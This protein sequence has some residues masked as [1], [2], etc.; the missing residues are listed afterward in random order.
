L[1][2]TTDEPCP[3]SIEIISSDL[4]QL[5]LRVECP[6]FVSE[7]VTHEESEYSRLTFP[8]LYRTS[9]EGSPWLP[10]VRQLIAVPADCAMNVSVTL[11][12][13][14][15]FSGSVLYPVPAT[16]VC[17]TEEGWEYYDHEFA[18]DEEAYARGGYYPTDVATVS[19]SGSFRGQGVALL[20]V[21]P[22]QFDA[23]GLR[24]RALHSL[25]VT[26]TFEG[27]TGG[28]GEDVGPF[29][30]IA[31]DVLVNYQGLSA[32]ERGAAGAGEYAHC[33]SVADCDS[34]RADYLMIVEHTL[35][36]SG[37]AHVAALA[38]H[39]AEFDGWNVAI[40]SDT[41]ITGGG[42]IS[43]E[44]IKNFIQAVYETRSAE[45]MSDGRLGYVLLV[46]DA[47]PDGDEMIPAHEASDPDD[48]EDSITTDTWYAC[49]KDDD[50][51][52]DLAIGRL[53]ADE[54]AELETEVTKFVD[55]ETDA[56]SADAW[57]DTVFLSCGFAWKNCSNDDSTHFANHVDSAFVWIRQLMVPLDYGVREL[58][59]HELDGENCGEQR[60]AARTLNLREVNAG[61][62]I[63]ELC[64][65]GG[66]GGTQ[67]FKKAQADALANSDAL[68]FWMSYS[69][70]TGQY[71]VYVAELGGWD[72]F[73][74]YLMHGVGPNGVVGYFGDSEGSEIAATTYLGTYVWEALFRNRERRLGEA[75][76]YA[77]MKHFSVTGKAREVLSYT[78][79]G[80][81]A[82]DVLIEDVGTAGYGAAPD[83]LVSEADLAT[84]PQFPSVGGTVSLRAL[85]HNESNYN[86]DSAIDIL[87][88]VWERDASVRLF[89]GTTTASPM[90]WGSDVAEVPWA[91]GDPDIGHL[92]LRV[93]VD[94]EDSQSELSE[95]NNM[96]EAPFGVYFEREGFPIDTQGGA[97]LAVTLADIHEAPGLEV[98]APA[99]SPGRLW[100]RT[101]TGEE[102]WTFTAPSDATL[103]GAPAVGDLTM[104]GER[105]VALS[106]GDYV[107]VRSGATGDEKAGFPYAVSGAG[108]ACA[109]GDFV[110]GDGA[111]EILVE[112]EEVETGHGGDLEVFALVFVTDDGSDSWAWE[113][114]ISAVV[115]NPRE[116]SPAVADLNGDGHPDVVSSTHGGPG[117][118][119]QVVVLDG[120]TSDPLWSPA[121]RSLGIWEPDTGG[122]AVHPCN[123][124]VADAHPGSA[125]LEVLCG[126]HE[127]HCFTVTGDVAVPS[128]TVQGFMSGLAATDLDGDG[129]VEIVAGTYGSP[130]HPGECGGYLYVF[131]NEGG[132]W[133]AADS[134]SL[135]YSCT[136]QPVIA[137][138][139][140]DSQPE[141]IIGSSCRHFVGPE[142]RDLSHI[143]ILTFDP[144]TGSLDQF[145]EID[146][147]L[148]FWG[149]LVSTP[150]VAD[151]D[152]NEAVELWLV[153]GEGHLH[154]LEH[155]S[156]GQPSRWASYQHDARHTGTYET[157]VSGAYPD[158]AQIS[159]WGDYLMTGDVEIDGTS[160]ML[161]QPGTTVRVAADQD[162]Q[163]AGADT[164]LT[165]LVID[166]GE[167]AVAGLAADPVC[168]FSA[169]DDPEPGDWQGIRLLDDS[170]GSLSNCSVRHAFIGVDAE[171]LDTVV[172]EHCKLED[173]DVK[174]VRCDGDAGGSG[175]SL[176]GNVVKE[177]QV[178]IELHR[179]S[180]VVVGDSIVNCQSHGM[181]IY[182]DYGSKIVSNTL[183]APPWAQT[184]FSGIYVQASRESLRIANNLITVPSTAIQYEL[185]WYTDEGRIEDNTIAGLESGPCPKGMS[186][187]DG[188]P[189]VRGNVVGGNLHAAYWIDGW[190]GA[191]PELGEAL[192][193]TSC[194]SC[195]DTTRPGCNSVPTGTDPRYYVRVT[196]GFPN[197]VKAE[198][199]WWEYQYEKI[200]RGKFVGPVDWEPP[201]ASD[202]A[203]RGESPEGP[204]SNV[205]FA[206]FQNRPNPFNPVTTI[207]FGIP[208]EVSVR[209]G[210][211]DLAGRRVRTLVDV[212]KEPGWYE[213]T[214]DGRN[215][216]GLLVASGV[217]FCRLEAG[218]SRALRK[219]VVL[220]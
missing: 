145:A 79:L 92:I 103:H 63:V 45:H 144:T 97:G 5:V 98:L 46:G 189:M 202:P 54:V 152:E 55:Y 102:L 44:F 12:D 194:P 193:D 161:I 27:G 62:H 207:R 28:L 175:I 66:P 78:L 113:S 174:G 68:P 87:F 31:E 126:G 52:P 133:S 127:L 59:A 95:D 201:L 143:D 80:D 197:T 38:Q 142:R 99:R 132:A 138:L 84:S 136:G 181:K 165:E 155:W 6:G 204:A 72:C 167:L 18:K 90:A 21:Y 164:T 217:Y 69:C 37:Y 195:T 177:T 139:N 74:E 20:T 182:Q 30:R 75:I 86:P 91:P 178:G 112:R 111:L 34:I 89:A 147:P 151:A 81:P 162:D 208:Q 130:G 47:R 158:G 100:V 212:T 107:T 93:T 70:Y 4:E 149:S 23:A 171:S 101:S 118:S 64:V 137:D 16:V 58:H 14:V 219:L 17:Y 148:F 196:P 216:A 42:T 15:V 198:C 157:P 33:T 106:Y 220:K 115:P 141:I 190:A 140:G 60:T 159:W 22:L 3:P 19:E 170:I 49:V 134:V 26:L 61:R 57:R 129:E 13:S 210:I 123:P 109:L 51:Y 125:G 9:E 218:R 176:L 163:H 105:E 11:G 35:M 169:A 211:Y 187:Y 41:T 199:N 172:I 200:D 184:A 7:T 39:R 180:A 154:S 213:V 10:A 117:S 53:C 166:G 56:S 119:G 108:S 85:V 146:R 82:L 36:D 8:G 32:P 25:V 76:T 173:I 29:G 65:H 186:F 24:T 121:W 96:A 206:L 192:S 215:D 1:D 116:S 191:R 160:T 88:E 2:G 150:A 50:Y 135:E 185:S 128:R 209:L 120:A 153:D 40:V 205:R 179:C 168:V 43:D 214:W 203:G 188:R 73:G 131:E 104:D 48:E 124:I 83:Y 67:T 114:T 77:K 122:P 156:G 94:P 110:E 71:D 183:A